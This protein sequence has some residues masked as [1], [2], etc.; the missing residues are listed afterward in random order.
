MYDKFSIPVVNSTLS[1]FFLCISVACVPGMFGTNCASTCTCIHGASCNHVTGICTC[2]DGFIGVNCEKGKFC[3][4]IIMPQ[5][6]HENILCGA[7][8]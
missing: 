1:T 6:V 3:W 2:L 7:L 4:H 8:C 5:V